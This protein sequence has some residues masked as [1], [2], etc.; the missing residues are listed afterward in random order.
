LRELV[1]ALIESAR[2]QLDTAVYDLEGERYPAAAVWAYQACFTACTALLASKGVYKG[3]K[4]PSHGGTIQLVGKWIA[5][6]NGARLN[7]LLR[8]RAQGMYPG[9]PAITAEE[10]RGAVDFAREFLGKISKLI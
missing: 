5:R 9:H 1:D 4:T 6:E 10:A 3:G 2:E 7:E 8:L